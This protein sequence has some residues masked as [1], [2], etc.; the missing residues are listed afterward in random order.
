MCHCGGNEDT[1]GDSGGGGIDNNQQSTK[2]GG[3]NGK[4]ND[5]DNRDDDDDINEGDHIGSGSMA[6]S[7]ATTAVAVATAAAWHKRGIS[8]GSSEAV[9]RHGGGA[10]AVQWC[11]QWRQWRQWGRMPKA[12][13]VMVW[14]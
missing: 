2:S 4:G 3:G 1:S 5:D 14:W 12:V 7:L 6:D 11:H 8:G 10:V 9:P 13:A